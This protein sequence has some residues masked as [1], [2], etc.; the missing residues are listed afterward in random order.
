MQNTGDRSVAAYRKPFR[1]LVTDLLTQAQGDCTHSLT[2]LHRR[3]LTSLGNPEPCV[4]LV[5]HPRSDANAHQNGA[6][7]TSRGSMVEALALIKRYHPPAERPIGPYGTGFK[8]RRGG[9]GYSRLALK[10]SS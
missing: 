5:G 4:Q 1:G 10:D 3:D 8:V 2:L 7:G 6:S 9:D